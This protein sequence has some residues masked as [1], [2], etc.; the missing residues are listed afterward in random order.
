MRRFASITLFSLLLYH[1]VGYYPTYWVFRQQA[2]QQL[3]QQ[4]NGSYLEYDELFSI[5]IPYPQLPYAQI[6]PNANYDNAEGVFELEGNLYQIYKQKV[7]QDTLYVLCVKQNTGQSIWGNLLAH[8]KLGLGDMPGSHQKTASFLSTLLKDYLP[9]EVPLPT[10]LLTFEP[11]QKLQTS[12]YLC[13]LLQR[14]SVFS[15]P[16]EAHTLLS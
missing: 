8:C 3:S 16:P 13:T 7:T 10:A 6:T 12:P 4:L 11:G 14:G 2:R 9:N 15:P 1:M 5:K